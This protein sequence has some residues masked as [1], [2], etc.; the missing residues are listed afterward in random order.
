MASVLCIEIERVGVLHCGRW[1]RFDRGLAV[2]DA[3]P[4]GG[5]AGH[6]DRARDSGVCDALL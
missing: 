4:G 6:E 3:G 2:P 5:D 1:F